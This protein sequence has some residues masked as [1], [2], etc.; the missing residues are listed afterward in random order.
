MSFSASSQY[1]CST[2]QDQVMY[3]HL[4]ATD[5]RETEGGAMNERTYLQATL[6]VNADV[7]E[8]FQ[9][10]HS[11]DIVRRILKD[12]SRV[13]FTSLKRLYDS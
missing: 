7:I 12:D 10:H 5:C 6:D 2:V 11:T 4:C 13:F 3:V 8:A 9:I 1:P